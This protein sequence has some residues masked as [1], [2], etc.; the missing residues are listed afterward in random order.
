V[1]GARPIVLLAFLATCGKIDQISVSETSR[2][3]I[4]RGSLLEQFA[5]DIGFG[6]LVEVDLTE[7]QELQ[8]QGVTKN[9]I[10]SVKLT[11]L[12]LTIVNPAQG[13]FT[14]LDSV[15]FFVEAPGVERERIARGGPFAAGASSIDLQVDDV[16][17]APYVVSEKM[18]I[19]TDARGNRPDEDT[20]IEAQID[21]LVDVNIG[22]VVCGS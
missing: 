15:E 17:L 19:T 12:S 13:D 2:S 6:E 18:T 8:N 4:P 14:F 1:K 3:T 10:D 5:G 16:E 7:S 21:L 9:Q 20:T 22:G 11:S